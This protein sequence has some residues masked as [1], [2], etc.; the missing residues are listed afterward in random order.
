MDPFCV[1]VEFN[2]TEYVLPS[3]F[4]VV[5]VGILSKLSF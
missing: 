2:I 4:R 3:L 1:V 5:V